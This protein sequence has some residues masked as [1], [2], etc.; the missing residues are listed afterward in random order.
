MI[1]GEGVSM[2]RARIGYLTVC[3]DEAPCAS[4]LKRDEPESP[5]FPFFFTSLF[6]PLSFLIIFIYE[7]VGNL[8]FLAPPM[9]RWIINY[10]TIVV[11][12]GF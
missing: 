3:L 4:W 9:I 1:G 2:G 8:V 11:L 7:Q 6:P 12:L 5:R 10:L